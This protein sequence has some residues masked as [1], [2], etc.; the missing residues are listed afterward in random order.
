MIIIAII[1]MLLFTGLSSAVPINNYE[2]STNKSIL[3]NGIIKTE[4]ELPKL[5][6]IY[7]QSANDC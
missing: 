3:E 7:S 5:P 2:K 1:L 6:K 4:T